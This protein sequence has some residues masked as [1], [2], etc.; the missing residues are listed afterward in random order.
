M[1]LFKAGMG[2][3]EDKWKVRVI[4]S[5]GQLFYN[6]SSKGSILGD[7]AISRREFPLAS[8]A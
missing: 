7:Q 4:A 8:E 1:A 2:K 6:S 3:I 5:F